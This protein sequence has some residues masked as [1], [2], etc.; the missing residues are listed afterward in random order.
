[1]AFGLLL[2]QVAVILLSARAAGLLF[3]QIG[4]PRVI[5]E[6]V[7]GIL[8]GPSLLGWAAPGWSAALF[9]AE[10][11]GYLNALSQ[12][13]LVVFMFLVGAGLHTPSLREHG[14]IALLTSIG[15][16][17]VPFVLGVL[18]ATWLHAE[19]AAPGVSVPAFALFMGTA[20]SITAFPV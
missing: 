15:S 7:A 3:H 1:M 2:L 6:M 4:Q 13:G 19:L 18:I 11:L 17:L 20:M 10:S 8:L 5:G 9:P 14:R 12:L 16:M